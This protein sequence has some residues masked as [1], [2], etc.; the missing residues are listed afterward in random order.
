MSYQCCSYLEV[1]Q[2][3]D[4]FVKEARTHETQI[5]TRGLVW[6]SHFQ[7]IRMFLILLSA[8]ELLGLLRAC[9]V[10]VKLQQ[11]LRFNKP[12]YWNSHTSINSGKHILGK[13][14]TVLSC[15]PSTPVLMTSS[16]SWLSIC[17]FPT[18]HFLIWIL[19]SLRG[20]W[21]TEENCFLIDDKEIILWKT[22][23]IFSPGGT[24]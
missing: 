19:I 10:H 9:S 17:T 24:F 22:S 4:S 13:N 7:L 21:Q 16:L 3:G 6:I 15:F 18:K 14:G 11:D 2:W 5:Q 12:E 1:E 8:Q 20:V 23:V